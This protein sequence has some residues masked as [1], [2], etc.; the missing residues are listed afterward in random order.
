[1]Q[2]ICPPRADGKPAC[3]EKVLKILKGE[4]NKENKE[5]DPR[6]AALKNLK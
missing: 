2:K 6:W 1:M 5:P 4:N 3:N